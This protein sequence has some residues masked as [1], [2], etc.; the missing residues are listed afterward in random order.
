VGLGETDVHRMKIALNRFG[1][2]LSI[3]SLATSLVWLAGCQKPLEAK[4]ESVPTLVVSAIKMSSNDSSSSETNA[5]SSGQELLQSSSL[6]NPIASTTLDT[7]ISSPVTSAQ[8]ITPPKTVLVEELARPMTLEQRFSY[9][10]GYLIMQTAMRDSGAIDPYYFARGAL[11]FGLRQEPFVA[12]GAMNDVLFEYQDKLIADAAAQLAQRSKKNL[13]DA[14]GFLAVNGVREG[15]VSTESGLQYEVVKATEGPHP[16][17]TDTVK[18]NYRL[19]YLDGREADASEKE[20][21]SVLSLPALISGFR[22]G[23][24]LMT[25][26]SEYR[27]YVHP[28]LGYGQSGSLKIEAN[29]LLIFDVTLVDIVKK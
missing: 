14:E 12:R 5:N 15:V 23:L 24:M 9:T 20:T 16:I 26:G 3:F 28:S 22:E 8:A 4:V 29:T 1:L 21:P 11:D 25:I 7:A 18:V 13:E 19:T 10:I 17:A 6:Q 27:F 2:F